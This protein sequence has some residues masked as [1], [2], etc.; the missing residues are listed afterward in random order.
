MSSA[1]D[2]PSAPPHAAPAWECGSVAEALVAMALT[3]PLAIWLRWP[4]LW[5]LVPFAIITI[6]KRPYER[7]GLTW[8]NLGSPAFHLATATVIFGSYALGHYL[9]AH[10]MFGLHFVPR[11]PDN[12][13]ETIFV[14]IIVVGLSEEFFFRGY[15]QT[16]LDAQYG[17]PHRFLGAAWGAGLIYGALLFGLCHVVTGDLSRMR[18]AFF[19]LFAGWLRARSDSIA[20]PAT[21]HGLANLL[22]QFMALSMQ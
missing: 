7:Y 18:T 1:V 15:L 13:I 10:W 20:V 8:R 6:T 2:P 12:V 19:G 17:R 22:Y 21:Y 5:F 9:V 3:L 14:Q 16:Q 4:T 11:L